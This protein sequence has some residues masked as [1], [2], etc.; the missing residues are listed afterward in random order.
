MSCGNFRLSSLSVVDWKHYPAVANFRRLQVMPQ[1]C[2]SL[3][4]VILL[5]AFIRVGRNR[6]QFSSF[7][8]TQF[9]SIMIS[10]AKKRK[11][12][13]TK[14]IFC[15]FFFWYDFLNDQR[16]T[17]VKGWDRLLNQAE[18]LMKRLTSA[19]CEISRNRTTRKTASLFGYPLSLQESNIFAQY[20]K[21]TT[22][23][24]PTKCRL[25]QLAIMLRLTRWQ[26]HYNIVA[27]VF[28]SIHPAF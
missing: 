4:R 6:A 22:T 2:R 16:K 10:S 23:T 14:R 3:N 1:W 24:C 21:P 8:R 13:H 5:L 7:F 19:G 18:I 15:F 28:L 27:C 25:R 26:A 11:T 17:Y 12:Q 20:A 9:I